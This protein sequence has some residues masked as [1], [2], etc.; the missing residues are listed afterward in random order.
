MKLVGTAKRA[1]NGLFQLIDGA[2][3]GWIKVG[4]GALDSL[5]GLRS[6]AFQG[7]SGTWGKRGTVDIGAGKDS[8]ASDTLAAIVNEPNPRPICLFRLP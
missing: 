7:R 5:K 2:P 6:V 3:W 8:E 1:G 4:E